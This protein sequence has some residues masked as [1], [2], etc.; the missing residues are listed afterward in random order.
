MTVESCQLP[1]RSW[2]LSWIWAC[3]GKLPHQSPPPPALLPTKARQHTPAVSLWGATEMV[4][5]TH[6]AGTHSCVILFLPRIFCP[7]ETEVTSREKQYESSSYQ[8]M[9]T[10]PRCLLGVKKTSVILSAQHPMGVFFV[11][12]FAFLSWLTSLSCQNHVLEIVGEP[13]CKDSRFVGSVHQRRSYL[14]EGTRKSMLSKPE[15]RTGRDWQN[16]SED[17]STS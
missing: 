17:S 15:L 12:C 6:R 16:G 2:Q 4:S 14:L 8:L 9:P 10:L 7:E 1:V 13:G 5:T 3:P 11:F